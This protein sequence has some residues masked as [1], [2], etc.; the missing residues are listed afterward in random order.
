MRWWLQSWGVLMVLMEARGTVWYRW[1]LYAEYS[2]QQLGLWVTSNVMNSYTPNSPYGRSSNGPW[3]KIMTLMEKTMTARKT[4]SLVLVFRMSY[5]VGE[6]RGGTGV[7]L[8]VDWCGHMCKSQEWGSWELFSRHVPVGYLALVPLLLLVQVTCCAWKETG[9]I[10]R[11]HS[12]NSSL[13]SKF[14]S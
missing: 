2:S 1:E 4:R 14:C 9:V 13:L 10:R 11:G 12:N 7:E 5:V 6:T 8:S 3:N